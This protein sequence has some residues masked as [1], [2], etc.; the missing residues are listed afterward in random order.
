[1]VDDKQHQQVP[2]E[3][4]ARARAKPENGDRESNNSLSIYIIFLSEITHQIGWQNIL[5]LE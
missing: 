1:V 2:L 4:E 5:I 3:V